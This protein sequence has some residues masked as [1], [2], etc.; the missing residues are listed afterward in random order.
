MSTKKNLF[1]EE[2]ALRE[3]IEGILSFRDNPVVQIIWFLCKR[4]IYL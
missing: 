4:N 3:L 1:M 2:K